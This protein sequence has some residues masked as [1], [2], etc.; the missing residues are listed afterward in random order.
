V[1]DAEW[2]IGRSRSVAQMLSEARA[3]G[4]DCASG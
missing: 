4:G 3:L 2:T 1:F